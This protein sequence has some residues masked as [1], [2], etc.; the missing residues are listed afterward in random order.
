MAQ[1]ISIQVPSL[2]PLRVGPEES[3]QKTHGDRP[4]DCAVW[5]RW[6]LVLRWYHPRPEVALGLQRRCKGT[7][8]VWESIEN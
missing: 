7:W 2:L 4:T 1:E 8:T 6:A 3:L 5:L